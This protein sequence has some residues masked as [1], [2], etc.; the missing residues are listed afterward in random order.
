MLVGVVMFMLALTILGMSLFALSSYE[1][2]FFTASASREQSMQSAE[3]G[4][5]LV[6][7]LLQMSPRRLE[8]AKLAVGQHG[9][10]SAIAY[11]WRGP[12]ATD[13]TSQ[14]P[15]DWSDT[16]MVVVTAGSRGAERTIQARFTTTPAQN[17]YKQLLT[18]GTGIQYNLSNGTPPQGFQIRGGV[19]QLVETSSDTVW[20]Q[21]LRWPEGRPMLTTPAPRPLG[22]TFVGS[23]LI[24]A[25]DPGWSGD[26]A[27]YALTFSNPNPDPEGTVTFFRSPVS[28]ADANEDDDG[29]DEFD[30]Y[31]FYVDKQLTI[32]IKGTVVWLV[33]QGACFKQEVAVEPIDENVPSTLIVVARPNE[34]QPG[35]ENRGLWFMGGLNVTH[36]NARVYL[37]SEGD[38]GFTREENDL[39]SMDADQ[40]TIVAGGMLELGGP[41]QGYVQRVEY[42]PPV[43]D[44]LADQLIAIGALPQLTAGTGVSYFLARST[45]AE[46]TPR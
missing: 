29:P 45:W 31:S 14:G 23:K 38:I 37:V 19:W 21:L 13:T 16:L 40:V 3:S 43:M 46:T 32:R 5:E 30:W 24:G 1:A 39:V 9:I 42:E 4:M 15:V 11:Q 12:L 10:T 25:D 41:R 36:D 27:P 17:P 18:A 20:T 34:R 8:N 22:N 6:K 44:A 35:F 7:L 28:P 2:Q 26:H 33:P